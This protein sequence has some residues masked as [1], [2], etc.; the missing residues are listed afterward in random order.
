LPDSSIAASE[1]GCAVAGAGGVVVDPGRVRGRA[2]RVGAFRQPEHLEDHR[3]LGQVAEHELV[4][5]VHHVLLERRRRTVRGEVDV[6]GGDEQDA[7]RFSA[8]V[9]V[10]AVIVAAIWS[11]TI[12]VRA[13]DDS[14]ALVIVSVSVETVP[15]PA[16]SR[17]SACRLHPGRPD[18]RVERH[19]REQ[20]ALPAATTSEVPDA[21][22]DGAVATVE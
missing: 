8:S 11:P 17:R 22:G 1:T 5:G 16:R 12:T 6:V 15:S 13:L 3:H 4:R 2:R 7:P 20:R 9:I 14:C 10:F 19:G 18:G 21:A